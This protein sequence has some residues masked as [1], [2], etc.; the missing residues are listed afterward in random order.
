[1]F[2]NGPVN[3]AP[4][5]VRL[6]QFRQ[7]KKMAQRPEPSLP[8]EPPLAQ[9]IATANSTAIDPRLITA[10]PPPAPQ[11]PVAAPYAP[12]PDTLGQEPPP[13]LAQ[14]M[15]ANT[16]PVAAPQSVQQGM[17][18]PAPLVLPERSYEL[19]P[20]VEAPALAP[21]P[22]R[23]VAAESNR[24]LKSAL[25]P[26]L[27][28][29]A[30]GGAPGALAGVTGAMAGNKARSDQ[31]AAAKNQEYSTKRAND[32]QQYGLDRQVAGDKTARVTQQMRTDAQRDKVLTDAQRLE[33]DAWNK[34]QDRLARARTLEA[35]DQTKVVPA[36]LTHRAKTAE[37]MST[38]PEDAQIRVAN[39]FNEIAASLGRPDLGFTIPE[40]GPVFVMTPRDENLGAMAKLSNARTKE[41]P[42]LAGNTVKKTAAEIANLEADNK[43]ADSAIKFDQWYKKRAT[44]IAQ[45]RLNAVTEKAALDKANKGV[46][47]WVEAQVEIAERM[48]KAARL[49]E[50]K[51]D[52]LGEETPPS[53][54]E[55]L[56]ANLYK[57]SADALA[58]QWGKVRR[59]DSWADIKKPS[60]AS[61]PNTS[62][63]SIPSG[64]TAPVTLPPNSSG[65]RMI[66]PGSGYR[67]PSRPITGTATPSPSRATPAP[68]STPA[69]QRATPSPT[70]KPV[71][72]MSKA[73]RI[74]EFAREA[75]RIAA[76]MKGK[77]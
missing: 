13:R 35:T 31:E 69:P 46:K 17:G 11:A 12:Q 49:S 22:T 6:M 58:A 66:Q 60:T 20:V 30:L 4:S 62:Q 51:K 33:W 28:G 9:Q 38:Q 14:F 26:G 41:V 18:R 34:E 74:E 5:L 67:P 72:M 48:A 65:V 52:I 61:A 32:L 55:I 15:G 3:L 64:S 29:L 76:Q 23:D 7:R 44:K 75:A 19:P 68:R 50:V 40:K 8:G 16:Q 47:S 54:D 57:E 27:V 53:D 37:L 42:V 25:V 56:A 21:A 45:G 59:G 1:M 39:D 71:K 2:P 73:E 63:Y 10:I 24:A 70:P 36:L 77:K 43:R